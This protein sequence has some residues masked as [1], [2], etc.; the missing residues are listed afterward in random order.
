MIVE[1]DYLE[2]AVI[3]GA[4][5]LHGRL[6]ILV[7]TDIMDRFTVG[8]EIFLKE[9][10]KYNKYKVLEFQE[11]KGKVCRLFLEG[12]NDRDEALSYK[13]KGI[14]IEKAEA[15]RTRSEYLEEDSYYYYELIGCT[16]YWKEKQFGRVV[17]ILEAGAGEILIIETDEG[18]R[19]MVP[20]VESM[21]DTAHVFEKRIDIDPV[22]GL[23]D[24]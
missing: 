9:E 23:F 21:V 10:G 19:H 11:Q 18:K 4:H 2:I 16:V 22:E 12:I 7:L 15:E 8:R 14:Y 13:G 3:T 20:F 17:D 1:D 6:R 24:D 5:S